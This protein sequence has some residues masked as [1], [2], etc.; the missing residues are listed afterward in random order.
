VRG[1]ISLVLLALP[2][3]VASVQAQAHASV[4]SHARRV[5]RLADGRIVTP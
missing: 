2:P 1:V 3:C 5:I 4:M